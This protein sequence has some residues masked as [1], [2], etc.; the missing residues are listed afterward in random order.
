VWKFI[1]SSFQSN[2]GSNQL[3]KDSFVQS[4]VMSTVR[5]TARHATHLKFDFNPNTLEIRAVQ[6]PQCE[7]HRL[8]INRPTKC[9]KEKSP[10]DG[11][12]Q[13]QKE[14]DNH[15]LAYQQILERES[16]SDTPC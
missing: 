11:H 5:S 1:Y 8:S 13:C 7:D 10:S 15:L 3:E 12:C 16:R 6:S 2:Y 14:M 4:D 9:G